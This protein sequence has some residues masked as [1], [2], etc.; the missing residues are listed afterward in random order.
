VYVRYRYGSLTIGIGP[1]LN[2]AVANG[3]GATAVLRRKVGGPWD[4]T[5]TF[6]RLRRFGRGRIVWPKTAAGWT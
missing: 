5:M 2:T 3:V 4:G 6:A 1:S